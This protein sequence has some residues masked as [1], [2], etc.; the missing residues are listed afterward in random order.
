MRF[1]FLLPVLLLCAMHRLTAQSIRGLV[2]DKITES[3]LPG[4]LIDLPDLSEPRGAVSDVNG[5]F[6]IKDL[7]PGRYQLRVRY[8]GDS[9]FKAATAKR[10]VVQIRR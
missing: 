9:E 4:A 8:L 7:A 6:V 5:V 10:L 3:P 1:L 2:L